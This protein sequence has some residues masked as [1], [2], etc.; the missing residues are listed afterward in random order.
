M[1]SHINLDAITAPISEESPVGEDLRYTK[2]YDEIKE[3]RR[4]DDDIP[5]GDWQRENK[6][7]DWDKVIRVSI[8]ALTNRTK[9][10][11]IAAW[12]S[13]ALAMEEG[14]EGV[15]T[16][17]QTMTALL[18]QFWETAYPLIEDN[19]Y[20]YRIAPFELLN[21]KLTFAIRMIPL[22]DIKSSQGFSFLKWK[23]SR[24]V[25]YDS[26]A[27]SDRRTQLISDGKLTAD[28]F[29]LAVTKS[30]ATFYKSLADVIARCVTAFGEMD[31]II[32]E[33]FGVHSPRVS[34][35]GQIL[36]EINRIVVK[37][38]REQKDLNDDFETASET[39]AAGVSSDYAS[40]D[41]MSGDQ[42]GQQSTSG[43]SFSLPVMGG[44][45]ENQETVLW[46]EALRILHGGSLKEA[47]NLLLAAVGSQP[48]ERGRCRY[49]L[50][51][52]KLCLRAG[53]PDLA[54][55]LVEQ[56]YSM[57]SDLH[58]ENWESPAWIAEVMESLY[59]CL[60]SAEYVDE[61]PSRAQELF[62]RICTMDVTKALASRM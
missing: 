41:G 2:V 47:L 12:L 18:A 23:E 37:I 32:D 7:A 62:R 52:T 10:Y 20:D 28:E 25:G 51:V 44:S 19:D 49:R 3:A 54:K 33:K 46:N 38:C 27:K 13:E 60:M 16:G 57:I 36:E 11:Q 31:A 9:D 48:S 58:L 40:S 6:N 8:D 50:L 53:R 34:E 21:D 39:S 17:L 42:G 15:E 1:L 4:A 55:P 61:D 24:E 59:Q 29:D 43:A 26:D 22:T 14:F 45:D 30:S 35:I 56:L 5:Q